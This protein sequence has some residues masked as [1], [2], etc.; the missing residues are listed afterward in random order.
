QKI[1][2]EVARLLNVTRVSL[3]L[4]DEQNKELTIECAVG[5]DKEI[6]KNTRIKLEDSSNISSWVAQ[7]CFN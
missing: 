3:M 2:Q 5:I 1:I 4:L 7:S 6:V